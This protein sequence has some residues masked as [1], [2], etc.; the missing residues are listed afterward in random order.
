M[1]IASKSGVRKLGR[2][3]TFTG[4]WTCR[5]RKVKCDLRHPHC[6][7]CEK[8]NL[9]CGGYDIKLRWSKPMQFDPY[10][11]PISQSSPA[12]TTNLSGSV[13]EQ[14]YQRRNIDFVR[15]DEEYVYHED[16]DDELTMLHTPPI[17]KISDEKTWIL[18]KFGVFKGTDK[19]DKQYAPRKKRNRRR[20]TKN[21]E[22]SGPNSLSS[23]PS[24]STLSLLTK[25]T[26]DKTKNKGHIGTGILSVNNTVPPTPNLLDYDWNNLNITGYE[27]IS[28][29]LRD[30]ALLSA[31]TLQGHH[32]GQVQPH[33]V[34][35]EENPKISTEQQQMHSKEHSRGIDSD[36]QSSTTPL[37]KEATANDKLYHQNLKLLLQKNS[38]NNEEL[39]PQ[40]L[41]D[42]IFVNIEPR[43]LPASD[44]NK[45]TLAPPNDESSMPKSMLEITSFSS[46]LPSELMDIIPKTDLT[47]HGLARFLLNHYFND[48]ADKMTVFVLEKNPWKTLYFPRAL[49][50]LGD[51]AGLGQSSNSRNALLN[52]LLAVSCFHLQSKYP[53]NYKLQKYFLSLG[54]ELRNQA[55]H[56]LRLCLNTKS[57]IPEK[58]KDVLT[59]ILSMNSI[60]V[61][62]GTMADCQHHLAICEDFVESRM[63][64]RPNISE[65]AKTLHRIF[66]F[67][68]LIQD[69]TALDKVR[70]KEIVILPSEEDDQYKPLDMSN[71]AVSDDVAKIDIMQEG[72]FREALDENDGK[73]HIEFVKEPV[74]N[75]SA[76]STPSSTTPPIFTNIAT[77]TYYNK[78]NLS[79]LLPKGDENI[80]GTDSLYGL[81]NSLI[82]LF[83]DC[84]RIVR[85]NEYYNLTYLPVPRKFNELSLNFEKRLLKWKS[86]WNFYEENSGGKSFINSTAEALYHHT[87][88]FYF[89]LIIYYFTMARS[90]NCQFLQ[91]YVAKVLDHLNS[92]DELVKQKKVKIVPLIWQGFMAG[93]ACTDE[94][95]QQE[96]RKWAAKLAESG[97]GSYWGARQVML[98]VWRRRKEDEP[99]DNW[100]SIY[101]D[102]E[103]N[104]MLS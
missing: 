10:G 52:A 96:F 81:P 32:L 15:Y 78:S 88:S 41:I 92:M 56:F 45:I 38:S 77:E 83:S 69:S 67:L 101:K 89:S 25:R 53:R 35:L 28:S 12:T 21:L 31:V 11:V 103:M 54:I 104:L 68:K 24:S 72:L 57:S 55:S 4:C 40:A 30:D 75:T 63:K 76:D 5:G 27:W 26:D 79:K 47:V 94:I 46:D 36:N 29:E 22:N 59:A 98:E 1:G 37:S 42:D 50:A 7:R 48:V 66:S 60:D 70:A 18:K 16:M 49:M 90:L 80:I 39:D 85:H 65:K 43:S 100:Y 87:M 8:S 61:V 71:A 19:V 74:A 84:V 33:E 62:W 17:D 44:L 93:C 6:Q 2:A 86:E 14:Q 95:R 99:G 34:S 102:W 9:P 58:Y 3:K 97:M 73:I 13:D 20:T 91:N 82:L 23:S 64:L 51:L